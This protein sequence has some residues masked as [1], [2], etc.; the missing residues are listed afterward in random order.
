[1]CSRGKF[2]TANGSCFIILVGDLG[3]RVPSIGCVGSIALR[4]HDGGVERWSM[5]KGEMQPLWA[6][7]ILL[8]LSFQRVCKLLAIVCIGSCVSY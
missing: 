8:A 6:F 3:F 2:R 1:V 4:K 5:L 7:Q